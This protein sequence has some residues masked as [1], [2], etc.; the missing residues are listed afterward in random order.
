MT[1]EGEISGYVNGLT[2]VDEFL[3]EIPDEECRKSVSGGF[4]ALAYFG[5]NL[6]IRVNHRTIDMAIPGGE[7]ITIPKHY[8]GRD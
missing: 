3:A 8:E 6:G 1:A 4:N 2:E 5:T 7:Y